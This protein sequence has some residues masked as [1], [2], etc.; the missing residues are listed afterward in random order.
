MRVIAIG[1]GKKLKVSPE[2]REA[3]KTFLQYGNQ[4]ALDNRF[5][6]EQRWKTA[7]RMYE[8]GPYSTDKRWV[9][10]EGAP[11]IEITE[12]ASA[13]DTVLSQA[14]DLIF[15]VRPIVT[16]RSR[17]DEFDDAGDAIQDLINYGV[18]SGVW[19]FE[20]AIKEALLDWVQLG[21]CVGYVPWTKTVRKTDVREVVTLGPKIMCLAPEDFILPANATKD[22]QAAKFCTM[23]L[24]NLTKEDLKLYARLNDWSIDDAGAADNSSTVRHER[25]RTAGVYDESPN[26]KPPIVIAKTW[27]YFDIDGD[28]L[29]EDLE[30]IWNMTSGGILKIM[31]NRSDLA[32]P[33]KLE[34][35]QDR[36]HMAYGVGVMDMAT[37]YERAETEITNNHIWNAM[38]ANTRMYQAP[39]ELLNESEEIYPGKIWDNSLGKVESIEMGSVNPTLLQTAGII[40]G[41][42]Q[43][44]IGV[45]NLSAPLR[46]SSRT[47]ATSM[48]SILQQANRRFTHPFNNIRNFAAGVTMQC[49]YRIQERVLANDKQVIK[50]LGKVLGDDK[51]DLVVNLMRKSDIE[52][53]DALD[54]QLTASSVSVNR[55]SD[56]QNMVMLM[57]QVMPLYWNA[58]KEL[59]QFIA[60]PP[61]PGADKTAKEADRVLDKL[62]HKVMKTFD[63]ISDVRA[64]QISLDDIQPMA[65]GF[66]AMMQQLQGGQE[67]GGGQPGNTLPQGGP[68][69]G[70]PPGV[71]MQ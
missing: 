32:R 2:R 21:T 71:P 5:G 61:F 63:Q 29:E 54:V 11:V 40:S 39:P 19:N 44:R 62:Y 52:L 59:A 17:K 66:D 47:P 70:M 42:L 22:V 55:E 4:Q 14:E 8:G 30:V 57:T 37:C 51:A 49:L 3:L 6:V 24:W 45:Q 60:Q 36:A 1:D 33:F 7:L 31:Y 9:P 65:G 25:L 68:P 16:A 50:Q 34:C 12:G 27:V 58:K 46:S 43:A 18:E 23:R 41:K 13:C 64:L 26:N 28:G 56:R 69:P 20:A 53:T 10:F 48:L 38:I 35:Y 15:Q 67:G